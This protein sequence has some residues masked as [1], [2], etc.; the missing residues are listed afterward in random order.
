MLEVFRYSRITTLWEI[1]KRFDGHLYMRSLNILGCAEVYQ[2][3]SKADDLLPS[4]A[5]A[6]WEQELLTI[7]KEC[8][9]AEFSMPIETINRALL[10]LRGGFCTYRGMGVFAQELMGRM[11]DQT[12]GTTYFLLAPSEAELYEQWL[13]GWQDTANRFPTT[14]TDIEEAGKCLAFNRFTAC[15]FH[16]MRVMETGVQKF[17]SALNIEADLKN[18]SWYTIM[19][20]VTKAIE[21]MWPDKEKKARHSAAAA[22]LDAVRLAWRNDVMHPKAT[23]TENEA[24]ILWLHIRTFM[25]ELS[26]LI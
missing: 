23:Y 18:A 13:K 24:Q 9:T 7:R 10:S 21:N 6:Y 12:K 14:I 5:T 26:S 3:H 8:E 15:V 25:Q 16:L 4:H 20:Q 17:G 11:V 2:F 1:M 19:Q 22:H